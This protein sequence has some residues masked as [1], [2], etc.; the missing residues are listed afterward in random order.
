MAPV[1]RWG[2]YLAVFKDLRFQVEE[3]VTQGN[4]VASRWM[5]RGSYRGRRV[6]LRGIVISLVDGEGRIAEDWGY[7]DTFSLL[8]Q[9]GALRTAAL[10]LEVLARRL[11]LPKGSR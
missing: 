1:N 2:L 3:Q 5:L 4:R 9:L 11:K 8:R 7:S 6:E 10:G